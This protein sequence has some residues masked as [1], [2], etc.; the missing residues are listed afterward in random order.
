MSNNWTA[1]QLEAVNSRGG[2]LLV[3]A[4]AGAGK[5]A[6]LVER[7]VRRITDPAEPVDVDRLLVLTFTNAAAAEMRERIGRTLAKKI[8][9]NPGSRHLIRQM[10]L[11][12]R[13]CISTLH[14]FCL[15]ILRQ[16]FY[17]V[18]LDPGFRVADETEA[19][20]IQVEALEELF[21]RRYNAGDNLSF[22]L[23][24]DCYGGKRGD[25]A[26]QELVLE[27]YKFSRSTP[28]SE[29]WLKMAA[30]SFDIPEGAGFDQLLWSAGLKK[31]IKVE[32]A[33]AM[34]ALDLAARLTR[35]P[36]GP[37]AY[38]A[39]LEA[40]RE[41]VRGLDRACSKTMKWEDLHTTFHS[42]G[43]EKLKAIKK[44]ELVDDNLKKQVT[45]LRNK[46]KER[47]AKIINEYFS[48]L[49][50]ELCSDL[51]TV[52]P[53]IKELTGLVQ[54][55]GEAYRKA[56]MSRGVVDF[57]DLEHCCLQVLSEAGPEP[58]AVARELRQRF[59]EVL[60]DEY[61]DINAVQEAI[62][63]L[64]SRQGEV[65]PNLFM[66]GDVK[67]SIYRFRLAEPGLFLGKYEKYP[68][69][70]G[71]PER[72]LDL[73]RNFRSRQG[74]VD[75]VNFVFRQ[76]MTPL[77]GEM[78]YT[79]STELIYGATYSSDLAGQQDKDEP[80]EMHLIE[81]GS[82]AGAPEPVFPQDD[83]ED[84]DGEGDGNPDEDLDVAQKEAYLAAV[85]IKEIVNG[86]AGKKPGLM[87]YDNDQKHYRPAA[88]RDVVVLLRATSGYVN[89]FVEEFRKAGVP[90]YAEQATGYF[91]ATEVETVLSLLKVIDNPRQDIPLAGVLRSPIVGINAGELAEI[92][93][94]L[95]R[96]DFLDAV[97][98]AAASGLGAISDRLTDFLEKLEGWRTSARHGSLADLIW[99]L[100]RETGYYDFI[101][102]LPGGEQRQANLRALHNRARQFEDTAFRGLFL[103][104]RYIE[105]VKDSGRDLGAAR[106][107]NEKENVVRI[108]SIHKS[109]GLEFPVVFVA[110][111]GKKFNFKGL[112]RTMLL[113]K[114]LGIGPQLINAETRI[115]YPTVAKLALKHKLK[116]EA[117]AEELRILYVAMTRAR[118]KLILIGSARNLLYCARRWCGPVATEGWALPDGELAGAKTY[119][120]WL[121][122]VLARHRGG[123]QI[124]KLALCEDEPP[125]MVA[126]DSSRW[127]VFFPGGR[128]ATGAEKQTVS[129]FLDRVRRKESVEPGSP[130]ADVIKSWLDWSYPAAG[131][132]GCAAKSSVTELKRRFD[133]QAVE[134]EESQ[135][136]FRQTIG[137]RPLFMQDR[138]LTTSEMGSVLHLVMQSLDLKSVADAGAIK[139]QVG[140]MVERELLTREQ[141]ESV[142]VEQII[143]FFETPVGQRVL[144]GHEVLREL[145][146]TLALPVG[147]IYPD[148]AKN[149][150]E[151]VLVQGVI[152][153]LVDEGDGVLLLDYK[154]DRVSGDQLEQVAAR[155]R[156]QLNLYARAV[157]NIFGKR[158]K[159]KYLYLFNLGLEVRSD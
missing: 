103:F 23:L 34:T 74:V 114:D 113:H 76:L 130:L 1:E 98:A 154:T 142:P 53:L 139:E 151:I 77:V 27:V 135:R 15:D 111:L 83:P 147:E 121:V 72:R 57:N 35:R 150:T 91:E 129:E 13:A 26:L 116:M 71:G 41:T 115:T 106:I 153:C 159:D 101:G 143:S 70:P 54:D 127:A 93:L 12:N 68:P 40:D 33:S 65:T 90:V 67:Q 132:V 131:L 99:T 119:L 46:V 48:R 118:E 158:V 102:G 157:E 94:C 126:D 146:F 82:Q 29:D 110:G 97:V 24:V 55:F 32:L 30:A 104:L 144:A 122:P 38:L 117:L 17:R 92:R 69:L 42:A 47:V 96:G 156:G 100:Y 75:A 14:S 84:V 109:K 60:V 85:R 140:A 95:H 66:V 64:V 145:P 2:N 141:A 11:L 62:L 20:L 4:A 45:E 59:V 43:F 105:R 88:Y 49:P 44:T 108:M 18:D 39:N 9:E 6:V 152:D 133:L 155:Y 138:G 8:G 123:T 120:D 137:G 63:Q 134:E 128:A 52:A 19:A 124:R 148:A 37:R 16:H 56:K 112:N 89:S 10:S 107:L 25:T 51:R 50:E 79:R 5:T 87:I 78:A 86:Y 125:A 81:C 73:A 58:S 61:Q 21:E 31:A 80:V 36:G 149:S 7:V 22:H 28:N 3:A 136:D